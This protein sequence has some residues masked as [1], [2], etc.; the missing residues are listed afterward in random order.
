MTATDF[1][2]PAFVRSMPMDALPPPMAMTGALGWA[3]A[4]LFS[5]PF[6]ILMTILVILLIVW[7]VPPLLKFLIIDATWSGTDRD[8]CRASTARA[9]PGACWAFVRE[10][11]AYFTYGSYPIPQRWRVDIFFAMLAVGIA[12][13]L[14]LGAP[15]RDLGALY[16][17]VVLPIVSFI[18][19]KGWPLIGLVNVDTALWG[20]ALGTIVAGPAGLVVSLP[21]GILL[22][23]GRPPP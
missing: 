10:R 3:R 4:N 12:W 23:L 22:A 21:V 16:F 19:L 2:Q 13:L 18:L 14:W 8:A 9:G 20:G 5:G 7:V 17:F 1:K 11:L 15:R 6:N